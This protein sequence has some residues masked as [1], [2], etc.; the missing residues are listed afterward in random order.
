[1]VL[2]ELEDVQSEGL[3]DD[4]SHFV[5]CYDETAVFCGKADS[6]GWDGKYAYEVECVVCNDLADDD[7]FCPIGLRCP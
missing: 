1:M 3:T 6:R 7:Y 4:I 2:E 5:C